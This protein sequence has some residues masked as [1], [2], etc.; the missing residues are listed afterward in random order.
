M[1][2][3]TS[4]RE[5]SK[6][7]ALNRAIYVFTVVT[8][9]Y[10]PIGFLAVRCLNFF[11]PFRNPS[12]AF[13]RIQ[14]WGDTNITQKTFWAMPIFNNTGTND[15]GGPPALP[16]GFIATFIAI[17]LLTYTICIAVAWTMGLNDGERQATLQRTGQF[18]HRIYVRCTTW[19]N[20]RGG[21]AP[22]RRGIG[23]FAR[24]RDSESQSSA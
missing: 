16:R 19:G 15:Q 24:R 11:S 1:F 23:F 12:F 9:L 13:L 3:A 10:T 20:F 21:S 8:V 18:F 7:I 17:P 4:L 2:N 22:Q 14:V 5:A 6:G